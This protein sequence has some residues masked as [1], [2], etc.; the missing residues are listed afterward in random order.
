MATTIEHMPP[1]QMFEGRQRPAGLEFPAC[2][3]C[4][5]QTGHSDLVASLLARSFPDSNT[6]IQRTDMLKILSAVANNVPGL[7]EEMHISRAAEK[8]TRKHHGIPNDMHPL[9]SNAMRS[10]RPRG[11]RAEA[12]SRR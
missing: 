9:R 5:N 1:I 3:A 11:G 6:A 7:L 4:N 2:H 8:L 12:G 10:E